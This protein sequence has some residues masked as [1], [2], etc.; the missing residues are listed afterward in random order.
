M[1]IYINVSHV[2][3][4]IIYTYVYILPALG[5]YDTTHAP[6]EMDFLLRSARPTLLGKVTK[7]GILKS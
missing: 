1:Y 4:Y 6:R 3:I 5:S 7:K 2:Y